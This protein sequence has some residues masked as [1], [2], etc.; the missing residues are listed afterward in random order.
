MCRLFETIKISNGI[1]ENISFH[2][3]RCN[4]ARKELFGCADPIDLG[5]VIAVPEGHRSGR[6]KCKVIYSSEI[7]EIIFEKYPGR[8][9]KSL[10]IVSRDDIEYS[11]KYCDRERLNTLLLLRGHCDDILIIKNSLVT[12]T[13]ISNIVFYDGVRWITPRSFL[14][15]GTRREYLISRGMITESDI[16]ESD[17]GHF[18]KACLI[19]AMMDL[20]ETIVEIQNIVL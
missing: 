16:G 2:N 9:I 6:H 1:P 4:K 8:S 3:A 18:E 14:L 20:G 11:H 10:K 19:N 15:R 12:D 5:A 7:H 17:I 13:S